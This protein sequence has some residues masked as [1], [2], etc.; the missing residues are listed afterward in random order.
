MGKRRARIL[1]D[2]EKLQGLVL[3]CVVQSFE[4]FSKFLEDEARTD[5]ERLF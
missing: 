2:K 1:L 4:I 5:L 3:T